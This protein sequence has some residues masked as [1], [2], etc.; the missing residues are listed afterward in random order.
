MTASL[1]SLMSTRM[2]WLAERHT[3][4]SGNIANADTPAFMPSD[5]A[6]FAA[7]LREAGAKP[8]VL[9]ATNPGHL[10]HAGSTSPLRQ[11]PAATV[12]VA[13]NGNGVVLE[14]QMREVAA[15]EVAYRLASG[16]Y[17]K[18]VAMLRAALG[19]TGG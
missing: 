11:V 4:L 1:L 8:V 7:N 13:P 18:H 9:A 12:E 14:D 16:L 19:G 15:T 6:P 17:G 2:S 5:L 3:V 10:Q